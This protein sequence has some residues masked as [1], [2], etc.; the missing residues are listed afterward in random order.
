[1]QSWLRR[2]DSAM[3]GQP[4]D[5]R[6][7]YPPVQVPEIDED[8]LALATQ[9]RDLLAA[10]RDD[11]DARAAALAERLIEGAR[12][13]FAHEE[14]LMREIDF[15]QYAR[16]KRTHDEFLQEALFRLDDLRANGLTGGCLRW[17]ASTMSWF[18]FHVRTEDME[19]GRAISVA[20]RTG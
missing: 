6:D 5:S 14:R 20:A 8:H 15:A 10:V 16:H 3:H 19:L 1:M 4:F 2:F 9:L 7:D 18:R 12:V 17:T 13:H 11:D